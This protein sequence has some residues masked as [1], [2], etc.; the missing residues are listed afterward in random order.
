MDVLTAHKI[1]HR[2][3]IV[4]LK[5]PVWGNNSG[6]AGTGASGAPRRSKRSQQ[7]PAKSSQNSQMLNLTPKRSDLL[8]DDVSPTNSAGPATPK[9]TSLPKESEERSLVPGAPPPT[10]DI[11]APKELETK[12]LEA[13]QANSHSNDGSGDEMPTTEPLT[14]GLERNQHFNN[15]SERSVN[16]SNQNEGTASSSSILPRS[17]ARDT[18]TPRS[19]NATRGTHLRQLDRDDPEDDE[20]PVTCSLFHSPFR[21]NSSAVTS[22]VRE[23]ISVFEGLGKSNRPSPPAR[24]KTKRERSKSHNSISDASRPNNKK[25]SFA[26][27]PKK[28]RKVSMHRSK[29]RKWSHASTDEGPQPT[30][31]PSEEGQGKLGESNDNNDNICTPHSSEKWKQ[32]DTASFA[33]SWNH[34]EP[35]PST[36]S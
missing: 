33:P 27:I 8:D 16:E 23:R 10:S 28:L 12:L 9:V 3:E 19:S 22:P 30:S 2:P 25:R 35:R 36:P 6:R 29:D 31:E 34:R 11:A 21:R 24:D 32:P 26:W 15:S 5:T 20:A 13:C 4:S 7:N 18:R 1:M 14:P 17:G